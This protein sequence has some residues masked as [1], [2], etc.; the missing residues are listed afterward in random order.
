MAEMCQKFPRRLDSD[1]PIRRK[2]NLT[3]KLPSAESRRNAGFAPAICRVRCAQVWTFRAG[4]GTLPVVI[5]PICDL[6]RLAAGVR[7]A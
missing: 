3:E 7:E 6:S 5:L 1:L 4:T 2:L